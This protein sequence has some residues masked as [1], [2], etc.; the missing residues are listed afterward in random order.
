MNV[1]EL[2]S[3]ELGLRRPAA[4]LLREKAGIAVYRVTAESG[5]YILKLYEHES[6]RR[7]IANYRLMAR[8]GIPTLPLAGHTDRALL[9]PD[10]THSDVWRLGRAEDLADTGL[11]TAIAGWYVTL[12]DKG[13]G[14]GRVAEQAL[15]DET[16]LITPEKLRQAAGH[17]GTEGNSLWPY[18][19]EH[20]ERLRRL[21]DTLPRTLTYNDFFWTNLV[22]A[23]DGQSAMMLDYNLLGKGYAY[24]DLRNVTSSLSP[25]AADVFRQAYGPFDDR[26]RQ[27]DEVLSPLVTLVI[28]GEQDAFP[29]W[30]VEEREAVR[31]GAVEAALRRLLA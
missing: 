31:S 3:N 10:V 6:D 24:G 11:A 23:Q 20:F 4:A 25:E 13:R 30:A 15:Y 1:T 28:A 19:E 5:R 8:L 18:M 16:D 9:I 2:L 26:E 17:S 7:E 21:I 22:V 27:L 29:S 14:F 12:H